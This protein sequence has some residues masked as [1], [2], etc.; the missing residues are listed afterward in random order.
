MRDPTLQRGKVVAYT[1]ACQE[2]RQAHEQPS[3]SR[4]QKRPKKK[5]TSVQHGLYKNQH[6]L[7]GSACSM[8]LVIIFVIITTDRELDQDTCREGVETAESEGK[9][10][11]LPTTVCADVSVHYIC[12]SRMREK[13]RLMSELNQITHQPLAVSNGSVFESQS[14]PVALFNVDHIS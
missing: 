12:D 10:T 8:L 13:N 11:K 6:M 1:Q 4:R 14:F 7:A 5:I 2:N 9:K 3:K